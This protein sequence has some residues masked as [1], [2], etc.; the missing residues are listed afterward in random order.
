VEEEKSCD[1]A[2]LESRCGATRGAREEEK[3]RRIAR[4]F[5]SP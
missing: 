2:G 1:I 4:L 5:F 3:K